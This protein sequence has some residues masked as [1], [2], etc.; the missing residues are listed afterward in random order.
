MRIRS[1]ANSVS[2]RLMDSIGWALFF[3]WAG[4]ALLANLSWT[5]SLI[6]TAAIIVAVQAILFLRGEPS[7]VFT[8]FVGVVFRR[9]RVRY[10]RIGM[11]AIPRTA[12]R[13]GDQHAR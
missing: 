3:V 1:H 8:W 2:G 11:K 13:Y 4:I 12:Y 7:D 9:R 5:V 6:G 10:L